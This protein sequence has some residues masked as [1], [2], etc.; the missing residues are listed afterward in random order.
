MS[1]FDPLR[2]CTVHDL[3]NDE[4][5]EWW[6]ELAASYRKFAFEEEGGIVS[7]DGLMLDG[8]IELVETPPVRG[9]PRR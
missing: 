7:F 8:W 3:L 6:P 4:T 2:R 1:T 9:G 5:I